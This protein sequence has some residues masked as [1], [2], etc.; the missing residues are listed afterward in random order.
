MSG[1]PLML[2]PLPLPVTEMVYGMIM[3]ELDLENA[4]VAERIEKLK[5]ISEEE[6]AAKTPL[7]VPLIPFLDGD[8]L[9]TVTTFAELEN[10][11]WPAPGQQWCSELLIG[12]CQH[13]VRL[14]AELTV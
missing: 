7:T 6:L 2:K 3:K 4:S 11:S 5:S 14:R 12:D 13:D 8:I 10:E 9:P 1:T